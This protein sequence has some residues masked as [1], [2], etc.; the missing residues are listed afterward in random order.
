MF[1]VSLNSI[2][3]SSLVMAT[4]YDIAPKQKVGERDLTER[5]IMTK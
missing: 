5:N 3:S 4:Q 1:K 2:G